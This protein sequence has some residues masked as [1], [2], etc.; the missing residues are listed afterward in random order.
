MAS[1]ARTVATESVVQ[2]QKLWQRL[3]TESEVRVPVVRVL[4]GVSV[5]ETLVRVFLRG[6]GSCCCRYG[7]FNVRTRI[8]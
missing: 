4:V 8:K 2:W 3:H 6:S 7:E 5:V 1:L